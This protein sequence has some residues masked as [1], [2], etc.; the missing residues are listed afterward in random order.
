MMTLAKHKSVLLEE[1][2]SQAA[3]CVGLNDE[4]NNYYFL[5]CTLGAGGHSEALLEL[6][7]KVFL[8]ALDQDSQAISRASERLSPYKGRVELIKGNFSEIQALLS[9]KSRAIRAESNFEL[10]RFNFILAD[11]GISS[12]Q[13]DDPERGLSF[14]KLGPLDMRLDSESVLSADDVINKFDFSDLKRVFLEGGVGKESTALTREIISRRPIK[15]TI[16][17]SEIICGVMNK[18]NRRKGQSSKHPATV[19]F[20]AIRIAVNGELEALKSLLVAVPSLLARHGKFVVI[21]FHSLEDKFV[22]NTMRKWERGEELPHKL[23]HSNEQRGI[24][25]VVSKKAITPSIEEVT[26]NPR[27]RS[28]RMRVFEHY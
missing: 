1:V 22:T 15:N 13:L 4:A 2:I 5:D 11:L 26:A 17:L 10:P 20:Q 21:S 18:L 24:G 16:E 23:P 14:S 3:S 6:N 12:D 28:A 8:I 7:E 27:A 25:R 19:P 9:T